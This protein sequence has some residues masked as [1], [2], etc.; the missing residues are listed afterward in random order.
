MC[1]NDVEFLNNGTLDVGNRDNGVING[2]SVD[3]NGGEDTDNHNR[4]MLSWMTGAHVVIYVSAG[5]I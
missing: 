3:A 5:N 1:E 2:V 4:L